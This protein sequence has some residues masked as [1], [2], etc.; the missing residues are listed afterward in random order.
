MSFPRT[1]YTLRRTC[2]F[3]CLY[4]K[5]AFILHTAFF[6]ENYSPKCLRRLI[7]FYLDP[8]LRAGCKGGCLCRKVTPTII[9]PEAANAGW[10]RRK[11]G[12]VVDGD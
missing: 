7:A 5:T 6:V 2:V 4:A 9:N 12:E 11:V 1:P 8:I 10:R 3:V